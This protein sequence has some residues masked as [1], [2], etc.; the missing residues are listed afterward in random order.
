MCIVGRRHSCRCMHCMAMGRVWAAT[1]RGHGGTLSDSHV[2][3]VRFRFRSRFRFSAHFPL[4]TPLGFVLLL[5]SCRKHKEQHQG[6][7]L[8]RR[9]RRKSYLLPNGRMDR[10]SFFHHRTEGPTCRLHMC[11]SRP[12]FPSALTPHFF[13]IYPVVHQFYTHGS[14]LT[15]APAKKLG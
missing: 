10:E 13:T 5:A 11:H 9:R 14:V 3:C 6:S 8:I 4:I 12:L 15:I 2:R 7:Y 1:S